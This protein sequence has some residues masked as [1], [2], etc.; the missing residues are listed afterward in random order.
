MIAN[1]GTVSLILYTVLIVLSI[2]GMF[3][4]FNYIRREETD[5]KTG[6]VIDLFKTVIIT[7][8][9]S[10]VALII[11][12]L[13][14]ERQQDLNELAYFD[15]YVSDVKKAD[16]I[17]ERRQLARYFSI[18][19]PNGEM[20]KS[21]KNYADS[22]EPEY[23][24]Y[25]RLK[26]FTKK[27]DTVLNPSPKTRLETEK[28]NEKIRH[29]ESSLSAD[30]QKSKWAIV[31]GTDTTIASAENELKKALKL[32]PN[33]QIEKKGTLFRTLIPGFTSK[34]DARALLEVAQREIRK[35]AY[36]IEMTD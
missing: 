25:L 24:E 5:A 17:Y 27:N 2:T 26:E 21:W 20:K 28:A 9:F 29:F 19:S 23:K 32:N 15:K 6:R 30:S 33:A 34:N 8:A 36:L 31:I 14:K 3:Y 13:F 7:T 1:T 12:D 10:T 35:D 16:G 18:V 4:L 22:I 11:T